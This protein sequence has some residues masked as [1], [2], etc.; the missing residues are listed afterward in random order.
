MRRVFLILSLLLVL[1]TCKKED[2][3]TVVVNASVADSSMGSI[4]FKA[5]SYAVG[6]AVTFS[7]TPQT[8]YTFVSWTDS[9]TNQT[10]SNNPLTLNP[11][12]NTTLVANFEKT[13]YNININVTGNGEVQ[14]QVVGGGTSFTH[15]ATVELTAV[16]ADQYSFFYWDNDPSDTTNPKSI[17]LDGNKDV[18]AK[19]DYEVAKNL[20]GDWEFEIGGDSSSRNVTV[21][22]MS[23]DIRLNVLMTTIVNGVMISQVFSQ[24]I[25]ISTTAIVIGDFAV[26]TNVVLASPTSLSMSMVTLPENTPAPTKE[27]EIPDNAT[28]LNLSGKK[29]E[30]APQKDESGIIIPPTEATTSSSTTEDIGS[31]FAD[32]INQ[33]TQTQ[34]STVASE[35]GSITSTLS[36]QS[37]L[38][39]VNGKMFSSVKNEYTAVFTFTNDLQGEFVKFSMIYDDCSETLI[40]GS[41]I[42][43]ITKNTENELWFT[44]SI[45]P[46]NSDSARGETLHT[47]KLSFEDRSGTSSDLDNNDMILNVDI[48]FNNDGSELK[49]VSLSINPVSVGARHNLNLQISSNICN[50]TIIDGESIS[51]G[52]RRIEQNVCL[53]ENIQSYNLQFNKLRGFDS[54]INVS[55][56]NPNLAPLPRLLPVRITLMDGSVITS[57]NAGTHSNYYGIEYKC[58]VDDSAI[59]SDNDGQDCDIS[60]PVWGGSGILSYIYTG[61]ITDT[62]VSS[63]HHTIQYGEDIISF[64]TRVKPESECNSPTAGTNTST[65]G[66]ATPSGGG[67]GNTGTTSSTGGGGNNS[68]TTSTSSSNFCSNHAGKIWQENNNMQI[69]SSYIMFLENTLTTGENIAI[70]YELT[71]NQNDQCDIKKIGDNFEEISNGCSINAFIEIVE[72]S[73]NYF[74]IKLTEIYCNNSVPPSIG[75]MSFSVNNNIM[76]R[77]YEKNGVIEESS[78][79]NIFTGNLNTNCF[80]LSST[81]GTTT[82]TTG[83]TTS[84]TGTTTPTDTTPPIITL[85][86]Q[87]SITLS[88][89][90]TY[91]EAGATANDNIDGNLT[92]NIVSLITGSVDTS[93]PGTYTVTYT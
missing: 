72:N 29:S 63:V 85:N 54:L 3:P 38:D 52:N 60:I 83:T 24:I 14:K 84:T 71:N 8:G 87:S 62:T 18:S 73:S 10:Y 49:A 23:V 78:T 45:D 82:T 56:G 88:V 89:G 80:D 15:G 33:I 39:R 59:N 77:T 44:F 2:D 57:Q 92:N 25:P 5:G 42:G 61:V 86:G 53:G 20:V 32:S 74:R 79:Y 22:R 48:A 43:Q 76:T 50:A 93:S 34:S 91:S 17:T 64:I 28:P 4:D 30:E 1:S 19:F 46:Q 51:G 69:S 66:T 9:S 58:N 65:T 37:F 81:T 90:D 6:A 35:T 41:N 7:A 21:I 36:G 55:E 68:G 47:A 12:Q 75:Y 40:N 11:D 26:M 27:S 16:P 67:G 31:V 70:E 13:A